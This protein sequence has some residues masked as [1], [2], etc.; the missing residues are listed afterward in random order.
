MTEYEA[1]I[2][3][4]IREDRKRYSRLLQIESKKQQPNTKVVNFLKK[5]IE[6]QDEEIKSYEEKECDK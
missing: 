2:L 4:N 1:N 3:R 6:V 5:L